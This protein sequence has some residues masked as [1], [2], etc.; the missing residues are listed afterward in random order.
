MLN[1][2]TTDNRGIKHYVVF[3]DCKIT[4]TR[5]LNHGVILSVTKTIDE[6]MSYRDTMQTVK[7][8][9]MLDNELFGLLAEH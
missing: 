3:D 1:W 7:R 6:A 2:T 8:I 9:V 4:I 5:H